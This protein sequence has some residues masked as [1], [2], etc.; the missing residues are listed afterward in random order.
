MD[1]LQP[2]KTYAS[3]PCIFKDNYYISFLSIQDT[4]AGT[5]ECHPCL[6]VHAACIMQL[7]VTTNMYYS[8]NGGIYD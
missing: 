5:G 8:A 1:A 2:I 6:T 7:H 3:G 4:C